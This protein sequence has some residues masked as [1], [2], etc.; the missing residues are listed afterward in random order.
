MN[1]GQPSRIS[2]TLI[3][4]ISRVEPREI[5]LPEDFE[6]D[7]H[8]KLK[9]LPF[10]PYISWYPVWNFAKEKAYSVL[11]EHF[12]AVSL[13]GYGELTDLQIMSSGAL[14]SFVTELKKDTFHT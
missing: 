3:D 2:K 14:L 8:K 7:L 12:G 6:D 10:C 5:V 4:E 9:K 11:T 1:F 13:D